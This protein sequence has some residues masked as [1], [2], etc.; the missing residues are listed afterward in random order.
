MLVRNFSFLVTFGVAAERVEAFE[1]ASSSASSNLGKG[2]LNTAPEADLGP[3]AAA[4]AAGF[5]LAL[6]ADGK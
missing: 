6:G 5:H 4:F 3:A 1:K 2:L